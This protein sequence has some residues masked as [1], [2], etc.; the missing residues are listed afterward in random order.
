MTMIEA[1]T[2][3]VAAAA[4]AVEATKT[5]GSGP[6]AVHA[7][8]GVSIDFPDH[9]Y[10][11]IMGPSGL[12]K[13]T[14]MP[15]L[16]GLDRLTSGSAFIGETDISMR[17]QDAADASA[18]RSPR[19]HLPAVSHDAERVKPSVRRRRQALEGG[20]RTAARLAPTRSPE[21]HRESVVD[22]NTERLANARHVRVVA[23]RLRAKKNPAGA[24]RPLR[25][26][27]RTRT[28]DPFI[29]SEVLYQLSYVGGG[30]SKGS[31]A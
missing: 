19:I 18:A 3:V 17:R 1:P 10:T 12:G 4:K 20:D 28:G 13:S 22:Q 14:L 2:T 23:V 6:A 15:C 27:G 25:A 16:A 8:A 29:T 31:A 21:P 24:G 7:P 26:D 11:A 5:Y 9:R 30:G